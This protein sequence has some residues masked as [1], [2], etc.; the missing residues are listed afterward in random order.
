MKNTDAE[1]NEK[2]RER[3]LNIITNIKKHLEVP[4]TKD[5]WYYIPDWEKAFILYAIK[6]VRKEFFNPKNDIAELN[7]KIQV[8]VNSMIKGFKTPKTQ[9]KTDVNPNE[10]KDITEYHTIIK[11]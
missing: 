6:K 4:K 8:S 10:I 3:N 1:Y 11:D 5:K 9:K 2:I 7:Y